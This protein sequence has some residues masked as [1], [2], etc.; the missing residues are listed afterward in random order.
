TTSYTYAPLDHYVWNPTP[1]ATTGSLT[2]NQTVHTTVTAEDANNN[3]LDGALV[4]LSIDAATAPAN[5]AFIHAG[6]HGTSLC[7]AI[8]D[9][10]PHRPPPTNPAPPP[11]PP[12]R[13]RHQHPPRRPPRLPPHRPPTRPRQ[14]RLHSRRRPRHQPVRRHPRRP[15]ASLHHRQQRPAP[16]QLP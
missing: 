14:S 13:R 4:Y 8:L 10:T 12:R 5:P 15:P 7:G 1:I 6:A 3:P 16:L 2:S 11:P 9:A